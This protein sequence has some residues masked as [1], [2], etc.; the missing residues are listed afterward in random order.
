MPLSLIDYGS[1]QVPPLKTLRLHLAIL[2]E[3][4]QER[5]L[6]Q[7]RAGT[8]LDKAYKDENNVHALQ[9]EGETQN[10]RAPIPKL[11]DGLRSTRRQS[12]REEHLQEEL[13]R[14]LKGQPQGGQEHPQG[15]EAKFEIW[16][17]HLQDEPLFSLEARILRRFR[18]CAEGYKL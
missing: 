6:Y 2:A 5:A 17:H 8:V 1:V 4:P 7:I 12:Q 14:F 18:C 13:Q 15:F 11:P 10:L 3:E 16:L 9:L